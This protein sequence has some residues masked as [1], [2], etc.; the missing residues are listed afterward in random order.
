ML[1][2]RFVRVGYNQENSVWE[3][4]K[5]TCSALPRRLYYIIIVAK[6]K[7]RSVWCIFH[8]AST[9]HG[10]HSSKFVICVVLFVIRV[11]L[12][13]IVTFYVSFTCKRVLPPGVN[14][15]AVDR[16]QYISR[17]AC[18]RSRLVK[19]DVLAITNT[20][21][22]DGQFVDCDSVIGIVIGKWVGRTTVLSSIPSGIKSVTRSALGSREP[23]V[24]LVHEDFSRG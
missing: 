13:L 24:Q 7:K 3:L 12:F 19:S 8:V 17:G 10:Q 11:V 18:K 9:G 6:R 16:Y 14:P 2:I 22:W 21:F 5:V 1:R 20:V 4:V 23:P 15:T